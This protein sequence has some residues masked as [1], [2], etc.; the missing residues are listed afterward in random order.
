[1]GSECEEREYSSWG[2]GKG[3]TGCGGG[4]EGCVTLTPHHGCPQLPAAA[5]TGRAALPWQRAGRCWASGLV[6]LP[7]ARPQLCTPVC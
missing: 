4:R 3:R 2:V 1:M 5:I 7:S 6:P